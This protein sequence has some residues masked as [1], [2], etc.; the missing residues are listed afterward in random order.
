MNFSANEY[1]LIEDENNEFMDVNSYTIVSK[2]EGVKTED[3]DKI[4]SI[5][6][7]KTGDEISCT[8]DKFLEILD[9]TG[10]ETFII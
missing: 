8:Y 5:I 4:I 6:D 3:F 7:E 2:S 9:T 10:L 1:E